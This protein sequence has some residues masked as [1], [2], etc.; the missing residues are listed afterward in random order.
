MDVKWNARNVDLE[1]Y[2]D[3]FIS[4]MRWK[5]DWS[6]FNATLWSI[7]RFFFGLSWI[8]IKNYLFSN[9]NFLFSSKVFIIRYSICQKRGK[10]ILQI[11]LKQIFIFQF[12]IVIFNAIN[13]INNLIYFLLN[14]KMISFFIKKTYNISPLFRNF[15]SRANVI[16]I[17]ELKAKQKQI[18]AEQTTD[19][20]N[21]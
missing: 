19:L 11:I 17:K 10:I 9:Y 2:T 12:F 4:R 8:N 1:L 21:Q 5:T 6:Y 15:S 18:Y 3:I 14:Y 16:N 7:N 20:T 13:R